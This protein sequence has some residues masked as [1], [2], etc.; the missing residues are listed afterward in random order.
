MLVVVLVCFGL[1]KKIPSLLY[2]P[3]ADKYVEGGSGFCIE[4]I[5]GK[6]IYNKAADNPLPDEIEHIYPN[7]D[8]YPQYKNTAYGFLTRGCPNN[9][10]FCIV[11]KKEG[12]CSK[13]VADLS[14]FWN[15]QKEIKLCDPNILA[16][17]QREILL[18]QLINSK[19]KIDYTQGLDAR[20]ID[21]DVAK[22]ISKTKIEMIHFAFDLMKNETS[23]L[24]GLKTFAKYCQKGE[25]ARRTSSDSS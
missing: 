21:D 20:L 9:C 10:S 8:L 12:L 15:G 18:L 23:I 2:R 4:V 19:A 25:R 7:Y 17:K 11:S 1:I 22:L 16:C 14:E 13:K 6:E 3:Q 24:K 5:N